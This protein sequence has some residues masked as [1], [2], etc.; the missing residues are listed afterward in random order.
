MHKKSWPVQKWHISM[1]MG[2][3]QSK[4]NLTIVTMHT[5]WQGVLQYCPPMFYF[6]TN[7]QEAQIW[8]LYC[9]QEVL[10]LCPPTVH[11]KYHYYIFQCLLLLLVVLVLALASTS[12]SISA[13]GDCWMSSCTSKNHLQKNSKNKI[14]ISSATN[15]WS[16]THKWI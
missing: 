3:A 5:V 11:Y 10:L 14:T 12:S 13:S 8:V 2:M 6:P 7:L 1:F 9:L 16:A 4:K 15:N